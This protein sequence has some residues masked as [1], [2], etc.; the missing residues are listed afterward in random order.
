VHDR[1]LTDAGAVPAEQVLG[2]FIPIHYHSIMLADRARMSGFK[3]ALEYVVP[4]GGRVLDLGGGTGVLSFFAAQKATQVWCVERNPDLVETAQRMLAHNGVADRVKLVAADAFEFLPPEPV[5]V[6]VCEMLHAGLLREKQVPVIASF[7]QRYLERF[8]PPLP[9]FVP[10]ATI[11]GLQPVDHSF[12]FFGYEARIPLFQDPSLKNEATHALAEPVVTQSVTF[13]EVLRE[14]IAWTGD[15]SITDAGRLTAIR[16][17]TRVI[18]AVRVAQR[19]TIDWYLQH[20]LVPLD[21]P[22][23]VVSGQ[24]LRIAFSYPAGAPL[25]ELTDTLRLTTLS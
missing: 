7:K 17:I 11:L 13:S 21:E 20:M 14:T 5:D 9:T 12:V 16:F 18:L 6:V 24:R 3:A 22:I 23:D 15:L 10:E 25:S 4:A 19:D 2:Q 1:T 8:G